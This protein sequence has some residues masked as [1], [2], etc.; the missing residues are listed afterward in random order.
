MTSVKPRDGHGPPD[1]P[2]SSGHRSLDYRAVR[3]LIPLS[4]VLNLLG[5]QPAQCRG[6]SL[7][8]ICVLCARG[9]A[10]QPPQSRTSF[11]ADLRRDV[12]Y[13]FRC[14]RGG[15]QLTLWSL[16]IQQPLYAATKQLC[17]ATD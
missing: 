9:P 10:A 15:D 17:D 12:W 13:C 2:R 14:H 5:F 8:G 16:S 11:A 4:R 6:E 3:R 7:R 1:G